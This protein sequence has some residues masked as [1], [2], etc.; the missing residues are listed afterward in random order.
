M[1]CLKRIMVNGVSCSESESSEVAEDS[2]AAMKSGAVLSHGGEKMRVVDPVATDLFQKP[3]GNK[4]K[5]FCQNLAIGWI[6]AQHTTQKFKT[7][8]VYSPI[9]LMVPWLDQSKCSRAVNH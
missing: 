5:T 2:P 4:I 8:R 7:V 6:I 9:R 3:A 1:T